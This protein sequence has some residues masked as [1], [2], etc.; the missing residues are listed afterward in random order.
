MFQIFS[1][2]DAT[3][4]THATYVPPDIVEVFSSLSDIKTHKYTRTP[5][6]ELIESRFEP[7]NSYQALFAYLL[8]L[9]G[10]GFFHILRNFQSNMGAIGEN[11]IKEI[12]VP[13]IEPSKLGST[14]LLII[15][16]YAY[17][18]KNE[19][20][21]I[22]TEHLLSN[23]AK[24][25]I[26]SFLA[27]LGIFALS[28]TTNSNPDHNQPSNTT[29]EVE[30]QELFQQVLQDFQ[31][32]VLTTGFKHGV[33]N[34]SDGIQR[35][36]NEPTL[37]YLR[38]TKDK[39]KIKVG[40]GSEKRVAEQITTPLIIGCFPYFEAILIE[41]YISKLNLQEEGNVNNITTK[42]PSADKVQVYLHA[43]SNSIEDLKEK[44]E[45]EYYLLVNTATLIV[46][47]LKAE[48]K[49]PD[50]DPNETIKPENLQDQLKDILI[51]IKKGIKPKWECIL[52]DLF[53][54]SNLS[55]SAE[56]RVVMFTAL[57]KFYEDIQ[58]P[59]RYTIC[60][61]MFTNSQTAIKEQTLALTNIY[62]EEINKFLI[63]LFRNKPNLSFTIERLPS[64]LR[65]KKEGKTVIISPK[66]NKEENTFL[67]LLYITSISGLV[68]LFDEHNMT[69][70]E[71][72]IFYCP[73]NRIVLK[74]TDN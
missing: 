34:Y 23:F 64:N 49:I 26:I 61:I 14:L 19:Q 50:P 9:V 33:L 35:L 18:E 54:K 60:D 44:T 70:E 48:F 25:Y 29:L 28:N 36:L 38:I 71:A 59:D 7:L 4:C 2:I 31:R 12:F 30:N 72:V 37:V 10:Y 53:K 45:K 73:K 39:R 42:L 47:G 24:N 67:E 1:K 11:L 15:N 21:Q 20:T 40:T 68:I 55:N 17:T 46:R 13:E 6:D 65:L 66:E 5:L 57:S 58:K 62:N 3:S 74:K 43:N 51:E 16:L 52:N 8:Y 63:T 69:D 22:L 41:H 56:L 27:N 32:Y